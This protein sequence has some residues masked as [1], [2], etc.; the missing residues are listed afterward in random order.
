MNPNSDPNN[1]NLKE[2]DQSHVTKLKNSKC[3][4]KRYVHLLGNHDKLKE[5]KT[6]DL[7]WVID[8][9]KKTDEERLISC[10]ALAGVL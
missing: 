7:K 4:F 3:V 10:L 8:L 6:K 9:V 5:F 2:I 1:C